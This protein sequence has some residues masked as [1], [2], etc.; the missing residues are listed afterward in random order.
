MFSSLQLENGSYSIIF[1]YTALS[2]MEIED[3]EV[4]D[5]FR[6]VAG[7]LHL[8]NIQFVESGNYSQ[9]AN[10]QCKCRSAINY[11]GHTYP[12]NLHIFL[13]CNI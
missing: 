13:Y 12:C 7:I 4:M 3:A 1:L 2:V 8:G 5:I 9:I 10:K 6:L 11:I